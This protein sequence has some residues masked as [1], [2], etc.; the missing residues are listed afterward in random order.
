FLTTGAAQSGSTF[1]VDLPLT[2]AA[3]PESP[4]VQE[5]ADPLVQAALPLAA[6]T[7]AEQTLRVLLA[8]DS[9]ESQELMKFYFKDTPYQVDMVSDGE[10]A[11]AIFQTN[12]F[13]IVL[14]DLQMSGMDGFTA[15]RLIRAWESAHH[16][17]PTP[18]L[19]LTANAF[20]EAREQSLAEGCT[21]LLT[22]PITRPQLL[23]ALN[24]YNLSVPTIAPQP[25]DVAPSLDVTTRIEQEIQQRRPT[26]L[27]HRRTDLGVMQ[28]AAAQQDYEA[29]RVMGHRI[30]GVAGSYGFLDIGAVGQRL[31]QSAQARDL[32]AIHLEIEQLAAILAQVDQAA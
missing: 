6:A 14:I 5:R 27:A 3:M 25:P 2:A 4:Q 10:Q 7:E 23:N 31:E 30:K 21:E 22:K 1:L 15:T 16:R 18:I 28:R 20:R 24:R 17:R 12:H 19:A 9:I 8:E 13:D 11:V 26:F 29:I 32:A